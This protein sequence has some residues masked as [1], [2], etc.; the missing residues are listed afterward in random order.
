ME[1]EALP[2]AVWYAI[3]DKEMRELCLVRLITHGALVT[4]TQ[5]DDGLASWG[6]GRI[7]RVKL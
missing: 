4:A 5:L 3:G 1:G 6:F 7:S 2:M